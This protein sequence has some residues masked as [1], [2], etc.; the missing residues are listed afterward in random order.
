MGIKY[1]KKMFKAYNLRIYGKVQR[2]G[3]KRYVPEHA[4]RLKLAGQIKNELDDSVSIFIQGEK[5][6]IDKL[7]E[8]IKEAPQPIY[9]ENILIREETP[10]KELKYFT[11]VY[12]DLGEE[13]QEGFGAMQEV[14]MQY[15]KEFKEYRDEFKDFRREVRDSFYKID[16]KY[17]EISIKLTKIL[18]I[19]VNESRETRELILENIK[20]TRDVLEKILKEKK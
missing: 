1:F 16:E 12:G 11:I 14:F 10:K 17:G 20:L 18:E 4:R 5:E 7:I 6:N 19:L 15:W 13:L 2:V 9:I 8:I 3:F